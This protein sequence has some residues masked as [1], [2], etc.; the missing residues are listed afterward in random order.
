MTIRALNSVTVPDRYPLPYLQ[1]FAA[2]LHG[3]KIFSKLDLVR[4]YSHIPVEPVDVPKTAITT[5]FGLWEMVLLPYGLC[6]ASQ[7]FQRLMDEVLRDCPECFVC[8]EDILLA[9]ASPKEHLEHLRLVLEWP[10]G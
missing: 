5:P 2:N 6:N 4:A 9:S 1:D 7:T 3:W 8:I 10:M